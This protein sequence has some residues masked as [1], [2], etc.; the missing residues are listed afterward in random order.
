M[1]NW[2]LRIRFVEYPLILIN[3]SVALIPMST[4]TASIT[5]TNHKVNYPRTI[6]NADGYPE[7]MVDSICFRRRMAGSVQSVKDGLYQPGTGINHAG[8]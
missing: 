2:D 8:V 6:R 3:Y 1:I 7:K 5:E 4:I